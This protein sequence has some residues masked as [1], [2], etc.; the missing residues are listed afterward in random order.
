MLQRTRAEQVVPIYNEFVQ[1]YPDFIKALGEDPE[2][3]IEL[4]SRLGLSWRAKKVVELLEVLSETDGKIPQEKDKLIRLPGVGDYIANAFLSLHRG[5]K[6]PITDSNAVR[7]W[8]RVIGFE[9]I[10]EIR[11]R[12]WFNE[13]C[14]QL[15]PDRDYRDFNYALLDFCR[16]I[17]KTKPMCEEC[18]LKEVCAAQN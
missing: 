7:L 6:A 10:G 17:C 13:L 4:I 12:K 18:P 14:L 1:R 5:V 2:K 3:I 9:P 16:N 15:T 11:R 8:S